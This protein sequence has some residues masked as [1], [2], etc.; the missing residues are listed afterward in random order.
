[1]VQALLL[2][3]V[4]LRPYQ[5]GPLLVVPEE[6]ESQLEVPLALQVLEFERLL[7]QGAFLPA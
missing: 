1:V 2:E 5:A 4:G 3:V 7:E 6:V